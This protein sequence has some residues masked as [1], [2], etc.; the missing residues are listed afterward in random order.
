M[1]WK[2]CPRAENKTVEIKRLYKKNNLP[3]VYDFDKINFFQYELQVLGLLL[4]VTYS[5]RAALS[6][7]L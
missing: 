6:T 4:P 1:D 5:H 7:Y 2:R 3:R